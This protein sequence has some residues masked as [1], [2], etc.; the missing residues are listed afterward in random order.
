MHKSHC[1]CRIINKKAFNRLV[2][3]LSEGN[4]VYGGNHDAA[5][6][7]IQFTLLDNIAEDA[8]VMRDEIFGPI[9][10]VMTFED[11]K[12]VVSFVN[13]RP[14]PLALYYFG[15]DSAACEVLRRTSSGGACI[16]DAVL[17]VSNGHLPFGGVGNSGMGKYH[18]YHSFL[19]FSN[20][21]AVL[22]SSNTMDLKIK[23]PP[24]HNFGFIDKLM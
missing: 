7:F 4:V 16:N 5:D 19:A 17:H 14:K 15:S 18:S 2:S 22:K 24:Y 12:D 20:A 6:R 21:K 23:S 3:Y 1:Y 9:L 10:P 8:A 13:A 11:I